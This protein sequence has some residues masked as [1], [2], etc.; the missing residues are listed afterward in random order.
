MWKRLARAVLAAY[1][2]G[3]SWSLGEAIAALSAA[4]K[5]ED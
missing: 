5:E 4:L 2:S 3:D 1:R